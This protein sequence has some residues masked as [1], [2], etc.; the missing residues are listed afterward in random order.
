MNFYQKLRMV[1]AI[2]FLLIL[3]GAVFMSADVTVQDSVAPQLS[4]PKFNL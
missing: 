1:L 2:I 4:Q 3:A